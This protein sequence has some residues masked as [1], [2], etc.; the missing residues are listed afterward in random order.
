ME[1]EY[2]VSHTT[3]EMTASQ[4]NLLGKQGWEL[5]S[6]MFLQQFYTYYFRMAKKTKT[7]N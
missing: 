1:Y 4:L 2:R 6:V 7:K 5:V 3:T